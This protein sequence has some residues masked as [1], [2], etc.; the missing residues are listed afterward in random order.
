MGNIFI[1]FYGFIGLG[2]LFVIIQYAISNGID[3]SKEIKAMRL[4]LEEIKEEIKKIK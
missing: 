2:I 4:E 1:L 3:S